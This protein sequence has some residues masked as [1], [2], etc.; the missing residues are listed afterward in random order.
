M[1]F[2]RLKGTLLTQ[3]LFGL[4]AFATARAETSALTWTQLS[5]AASPSA[6][7]Y[8]GMTYD[9]VSGKVLVFGGFDGHN[10]LNDTW[11]FDG[12][13]WT[14]VDTATSP[15]ARTS[16]QM[17]YD[18]KTRQ[19]VLFGGYNGQYLGDTWLWNGRNLTWTQATPTRSPEAVTGPMVFNDFDGRVVVFGG[20][21]GRF[22]QDTMWKWHGTDWKQLRLSMVPYARSISA[23]GVNFPAKETVLFGGLGDVNP[24]NTWT[25]DGSTWTI[26]SP[27]TQPFTAYGASAVYDE[28][29]NQVVLFGGANGGIDQDGTWEWTGSNWVQLSPTQSPE[30]REGAGMVF[31]RAIGST[32]VFGGQDRGRPIG[33]TWQLNP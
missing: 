13:N 5:P 25:Y 33:D 32:I 15:P 11:T 12:S 8:F 7:S 21:D 30:A 6:R 17:A 19:V 31:D 9:E 26:Q 24:L 20:F 10:Y 4:L 29:L 27:A 23:V 3:F 28:N 14:K 2:S 16:C 22:Y 18:R 1:I